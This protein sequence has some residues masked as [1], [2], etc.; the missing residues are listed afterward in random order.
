MVLAEGVATLNGF[1]QSFRFK[2]V[3]VALDLNVF[4]F[5][6]WTFKMVTELVVFLHKGPDCFEE[7]VVGFL[8]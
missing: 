8:L 6:Q 1:A 5:C 2:E 4:E 3:I 7:R